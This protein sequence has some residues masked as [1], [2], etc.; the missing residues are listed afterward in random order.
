[1]SLLP[2]RILPPTAS[3]GNVN[4]DGTVTVEKNWWLYWYNLGAQ[5]LGNGGLSTSALVSIV[6]T[7]VDAAG[8]DT[9]I[10]KPQIANLAMQLPEVPPS[11]SDYPGI[12]RAL[13]LSQEPILPD[14]IPLAQ[15]ITAILVG[16]SVFAYKAPFAGSVSVTGGTVSDISLTRQGVTVDT[17]Q[18]SGVFQVS[19]YDVLNVTWSGK[20]TMNFIPWSNQ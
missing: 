1:M 19:R 16:A 5:T 17:G 10:L 13:L 7:E 18:I 20:P 12:S 2:S 6:D 14:A 9:A 15:P 8:S 3:F 11:E 4:P